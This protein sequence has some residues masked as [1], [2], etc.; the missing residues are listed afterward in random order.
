MAFFNIAIGLIGS[1]VVIGAVFFVH[2][3]R[4]KGALFAVALVVGFLGYFLSQH[5]L[6]PRYLL[7]RFEKA[8]HN[9]SV[10]V[11]IEKNHPKEFQVYIEKIKQSFKKT[12]D[13][14][15]VT[16]YTAELLNQ[17][18]NAHL[19]KSPNDPIELYLKS[20]IEL[21]RYLFNKMPE[22]VV[23]LETG[24]KISSIDIEKLSE[25]LMFNSYLTRL[26]DAKKL[27]IQDSIQSS[28]LQLNHD[29]AK[30]ELEKI[31]DSLSNKFGAEIIR[32]VFVPSDVAIPP[33]IASLV[34]I[35]FYSEILATGKE[36]AGDIMRY[37]GSLSANL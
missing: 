2:Q 35:E 36:T 27:I 16:G 15:A 26:L 19:E 12:E 34:I 30:A 24:K 7:W 33:K 29:K 21:Y 14:A 23:M 10:F 4:I 3:R 22:A 8:L 37:V 31:H 32:G 5:Y 9:Q 13:V 25:D 1:V 28:I 20:T 18:F 11:L 17:I 6:Y